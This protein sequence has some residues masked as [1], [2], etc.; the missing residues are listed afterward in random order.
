MLVRKRRCCRSNASC[1][2]GSRFSD[3]EYVARGTVNEIIVPPGLQLTDAFAEPMFTPS[4]KAAS[5][6]DV[7]ISVERAALLVGADRVTRPDALRGPLHA[8]PPRRSRQGADPRRHEFELGFVGGN[9]SSATKSSRRFVA[10][11]A[12]RPGSFR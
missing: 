7:N 4:T 6:H 9:W 10:Y 3:G 8:C 12:G 5:G 11:L 1:A 2:A